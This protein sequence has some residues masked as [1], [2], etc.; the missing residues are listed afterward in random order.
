MADTAFRTKAEVET[1]PEVSPEVKEPTRSGDESPRE[2]VPYLDYETQHNHP[3][4][5]D[6]FEL[7]DRWDDPNGGFPKEVSVIEE[8]IEKKI[9][10]G[11]IANTVKAVREELRGL[12]KIN[13]I[14][15]EE[16]LVIK[17]DTIAAYCE[18]LM[19]TDETKYNV[20]R[21]GHN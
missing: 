12:E 7:G 19:K 18:F 20:R 13:G 16:R 8:Y 9:R 6:Y 11:D 17:V 2:E 21:Y 10:S 15:K 1:E 14:K 5:V 4:S 3:F